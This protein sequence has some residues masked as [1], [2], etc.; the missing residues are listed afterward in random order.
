MTNASDVVDSN[1]EPLVDGAEYRDRHGDTWRAVFDATEFRHVARADG[2]TFAAEV[3]NQ[4]PS[5][6]PVSPWFEGVASIAR[7]FGP[8][9]PV[10]A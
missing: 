6:P 4:R 1:G 9:V 3:T 5:D 10:A 2:W 8:M 7:D